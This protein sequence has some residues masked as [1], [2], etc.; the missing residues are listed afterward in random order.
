[1]L[2]E[3][4]DACLIDNVKCVPVTDR[5]NR[6][7]GKS[8]SDMLVVEVRR[9]RRQNLFAGKRVLTYSGRSSYR[10]RGRELKIWPAS[11]TKRDMI[12]SFGVWSVMKEPVQ[13]FET[14]AQCKIKKSPRRW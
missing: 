2:Q 4:V 8:P 1:M 3:A 9:F 6:G 7:A 12:C 10:R 14:A 5:N 13:K 11:G